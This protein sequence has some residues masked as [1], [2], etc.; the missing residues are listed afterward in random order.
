MQ[1][2]PTF[3][4]Q[5]KQGFMPIL[6]SEHGKDVDYFILIVH[7]LMA[8]LFIGWMAYFCY[9][10]FRFR[11]T[12]NPKADY[13]GA[14]GTLANNAEIAVVVVEAILLIAFAIPLW[15]KAVEKF[16]KPEEAT[17]MRLVAEQFSW[18]ARY[19]GKDG[20]FGA[21]ELKLVSDKNPLGYVEKDPAGADDRLSPPK[22]IHVPLIPVK[23]E[24]RDTFKPVIVHP[25][26]KDVIHSFKVTAM[27]M[28]Q[29]CMPGMSIPVH[30]TPTKVGKFNITCA[31]LCGN[32]H[33]SMNGLFV[34]DS[35]EDFD[36]W[37]AEKTTAAG[38]APVSFE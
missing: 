37:L 4:E 18:Q 33:A 8:A 10:L 6:A 7:W 2:N 17:V 34:V 31:Q 23:V 9:A 19:P 25:T 13:A 27:R 3:L 16:P 29:D 38:G 24:G 26:T 35:P 22:D 32:G 21:Q 28:T 5:L 36:K 15:A 14:K 30:F 20:K 1:P 11:K 12:A